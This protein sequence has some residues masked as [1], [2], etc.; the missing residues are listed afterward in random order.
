MDPQPWAGNLSSLVPAQTGHFRA[1]GPAQD[2]H[3]HSRPPQRW[4]ERHTNPQDREGA[5]Q[6]RRQEPLRSGSAARERQVLV[7]LLSF[8]TPPPC[9]APTGLPTDRRG[10]LQ[11]PGAAPTPMP[12]T[13][14]EAAPT[15]PPVMALRISLA[16]S[17]RISM[18]ACSLYQAA[19][20]VQIRLGASFKGPWLKLHRGQRLKVRA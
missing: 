19:C 14:P 18:E 10:P 3:T 6:T 8:R 13:L 17:S 2:A 11:E 9:P 1:D 4:A 5:S 16:A 12:H 15:R 7:A 20:G